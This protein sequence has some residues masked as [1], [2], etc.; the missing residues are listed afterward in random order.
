MI[1]PLNPVT[2]VR[3]VISV[4]QAVASGNAKQIKSSLGKALLNSPTCLLCTSMAQTVL[5]KMTDEQVAQAVGEGF[6]VFVTTGDPYLVAVDAAKNILVQQ[7]IE[8]DDNSRMPSQFKQPL[9]SR[10]AATFIAQAECVVEYKKNNEDRILAAWTDAPYLTAPDGSKH[11][12]P[13]VDLQVG[14]TVTIT[15]PL[16]PEWNAPDGSAKSVAQ[17]KLVLKEVTTL[18]GAAKTKKWFLLGTNGR[19]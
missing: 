17:A 11:Q 3:N 15:S 7:P 1:K 2:Q 4:A 19:G 8:Q 14:D 16:C 10:P 9:Q 13:N 12:Y 5:P 6:L 18:A